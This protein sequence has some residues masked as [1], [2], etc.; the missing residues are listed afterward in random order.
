MK[1]N[2]FTVSDCDHKEDNYNSYKKIQFTK[3]FINL[4]Q[5]LQDRLVC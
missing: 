1:A 4:Q 3:T 5:S 2:C